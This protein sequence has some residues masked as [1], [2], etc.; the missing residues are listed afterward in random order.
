VS[1]FLIFLKNLDKRR[2]MQLQTKHDFNK[3]DRKGH[4]ERGK[5]DPGRSRGGEWRAAIVDRR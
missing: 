3:H 5:S 4:R 2:V 1:L